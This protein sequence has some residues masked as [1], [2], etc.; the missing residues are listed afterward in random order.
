MDID[1]KAKLIEYLKSVESTVSDAGEFVKAE[2]PLVV[3]EYVRWVLVS[4]FAGCCLCI[5]GFAVSMTF[6][7][8]VWKWL[9]KPEN[10]NEGAEPVMILPV[11]LLASSIGGIVA[12]GMEATKAYVAPRVLVL[13]KLQELTR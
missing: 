6:T 2:L 8:K 5:I 12:T 4:N 9:C 1:L 3:S 10:A 13:E 7:W 11:I